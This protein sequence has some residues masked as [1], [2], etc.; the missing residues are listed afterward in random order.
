M[1]GSVCAAA[2]LPTALRCGASITVTQ[3]YP[4]L[5]FLAKTSIPGSQHPIYRP[6]STCALGPSDLHPSKE[7][8]HDNTSDPSDPIGGPE[9]QQ[10]T[11][12]PPGSRRLQ[13]LNVQ[14]ITKLFLPRPGSQALAVATTIREAVQGAEPWSTLGSLPRDSQ[15]LSR[16]LQ[17]YLAQKSVDEQD[18][19]AI[20]N[21]LLAD[22]WAR[23]RAFMINIDD[24]HWPSFLLS[25]AFRTVDTN[26]EISDALAV[27]LAKVQRASS[28]ETRKSDFSAVAKELRACLAILTSKVLQG[29]NRLHLLSRLNGVVAAVARLLLMYGT[30]RAQHVRYAD[31]VD[32]YVAQ[33]VR[34]DDDRAREAVLSLAQMCRSDLTTRDALDTTFERIARRCLA[35]EPAG[36][37]PEP[38]TDF[39]SATFVD[40]LLK[41]LHG[42]LPLELVKAGHQAAI[43]AAGRDRKYR[44]IKHHFDELTLLCSRPSDVGVDSLLHYAK[45][46]SRTKRGSAEALRTV[47]QADRL[48]RQ[49]WRNVAASEFDK[50]KETYEEAYHTILEVASRQPEVPVDRI[51]AMLAISTTSTGDTLTGSATWSLHSSVRAY[52]VCMQGFAARKQ[53]RL[54]LAVWKAMLTRGVA[55]NVVSLSVL[56]QALFQMGDTLIALQ[57][58]RLWTEDGGPVAA[59]AEQFGYARSLSLDL[60][61]IETKFSEP[62]VPVESPDQVIRCTVKA[63]AQLANVVFSGLSQSGTRGI[64]T[65]WTAYCETISRFPDA[66]VLSLLLKTTCAEPTASSFEATVGREIFRSLLFL[67]HSDLEGYE[68]PLCRQLDEQGFASWLVSHDGSRVQRWFSSLL[69]T[70]TASSSPARLKA[71]GLVFTDKLFDHYI[72]LLLHVHH[73]AGYLSSSGGMVKELLDVLGWMKELNLRPTES[74]LALVVLEI[75]EGLP[76]IVA[77]RQMDAIDEW[78]HDWL[79]SDGIPDDRQMQSYWKWKMK[80]NGRGGGWF[81]RLNID[82]V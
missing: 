66:P 60:D 38:S 20:R 12:A 4:T 28:W 40:A 75:E 27:L 58:L 13:K 31:L 3:Q 52:T 67:T 41:H 62:L 53:P 78:L 50:I 39:L 21:A 43:R 26:S 71:P 29:R 70:K 37:H 65:L 35:P 6:F 1:M 51:L 34:H 23:V 24:R 7:A 5:F 10:R 44:Q 68:N 32:G 45:A 46:L 47:L 74:S 57:Q 76:P 73:S 63:D 30:E 77:A 59:V 36:F 80:R 82:L 9:A 25:H 22:S 72:R 17:H 55:P 11:S 54:T 2:A 79:G 49:Q 56:L 33:L 42:H 19:L 16:L 69:H 18:W 14:S 81:D 64:E 15:E 48:L 8:C 61:D